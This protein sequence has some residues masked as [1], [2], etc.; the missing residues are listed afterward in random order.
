VLSFLWLSWM[1]GI[2]NLN[3]QSYYG[4]H[5]RMCLASYPELNHENYYPPG[6][7]SK[8]EDIDANHEDAEWFAPEY[9]F[10]YSIDK[11][12]G[13][14]TVSC[15]LE[16]VEVEHN[17]ERGD[18]DS[19]SEDSCRC[20]S[21][22]VIIP[23]PANDEVILK[24]A[25]NSSVYVFDFKGRQL[26]FSRIEDIPRLDIR[27]LNTGIYSIKVECAEDIYTLQLIIQR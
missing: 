14:L 19:Q 23:N 15:A 27:S 17:R 1:D 8:G 5:P 3:A 12:T 25:C 9:F 6:R 16:K 26:L 4:F 13:K 21:S 11:N 7:D 18:I 20:S 2:D 10:Q 22:I 24:G